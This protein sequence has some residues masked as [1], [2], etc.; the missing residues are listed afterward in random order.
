MVKT[1]HKQQGFTLIELMIVVAIIGILAAIAVPAYQ[2]YVTRAKVSEIVA[3]ASPCKQSVTE[4]YQ[5]ENA[6]PADGTAAG[7][8]T[9]VSDY[10]ASIAVAGDGTGTI[11][12]TGKEAELSGV[13]A[14]TN[15]YVLVPTASGGTLTW[16]CTTSTIPD[17]LLPAN[18][19][20]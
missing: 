11:T 18:C 8:D 17:K 3:A 20:G 14:T 13:D 10:V 12:V 15:T 9:Q 1:M 16:S 6:L 19:R 5:T 7:C 4:Y 2:D